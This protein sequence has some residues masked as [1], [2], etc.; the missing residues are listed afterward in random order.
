MPSTRNNYKA[1]WL[2][3][4]RDA[5]NDITDRA[6]EAPIISETVVNTEVT[7]HV[8][9]QKLQGITYETAAIAK[10]LAVL[11]T[12]NRKVA[13]VDYGEVDHFIDA[14]LNKMPLYVVMRRIRD[15]LKHAEFR[16]GMLTV[17][18]DELNEAG[19]TL[20]TELHAVQIQSQ[21]LQRS[22]LNTLLIGPNATREEMD[23]YADVQKEHKRYNRYGL[24]YSDLSDDVF[25][26]FG[27]HANHRNQALSDT[28]D[29]ESVD[30]SD[31]DN[32]RQIVT[33][34]RNK[35]FRLNHQ[36]DDSAVADLDT[37]LGRN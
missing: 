12:E 14:K 35:N 10:S 34:Q 4:V 28:A 19:Q 21:S 16:V 24:S 8:E 1:K 20:A 17:A 2:A 30:D 33:T 31:S 26:N 13:G 37:I 36:R 15:I 7:A 5:G 23:E 32:D 6:A 11:M 25:E 22:T 3:A 27:M 18:C 29:N 9:L